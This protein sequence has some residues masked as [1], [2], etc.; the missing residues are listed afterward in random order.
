MAATFGIEWIVQASAAGIVRS[1]LEGT[2][3]ALLAALAVRLSG[4]HSSKTR[5]GVWFSALMTIAV[6]PFLTSVDLS[7]G[8]EL[9]SRNNIHCALTV[10]LSWALYLFGAWLLITVFGLLRIASGLLQMRALRKTC[11]EID[12]SELDPLM[13]ELLG[14]TLNSAA[15]SLCVSDR[16]RVPSAIGFFA[17]AIVIPRWLLRE[18]TPEELKQILLHEFEHLR[19]RDHWTN[20]AQKIV[21]ALFFFH[22]AVWWIEKQLSLQR[23]MACDEAVVAKTAKPRA[24]AECLARMA[25]KTAMERTLALAQAAFGHLRQTSLRLAKILS[26]PPQDRPSLWKPAVPLIAGLAIV[27]AS[28][29]AKEPQLIAFQDTSSKAISTAIERVDN[30]R[31]RIVP[32][33]FTASQASRNDLHPHPHQVRSARSKVVSGNAKSQ[34]NDF[35]EAIF[36][37]DNS[38]VQP[39]LV[40]TTGFVTNAEM[41]MEFVFVVVRRRVS[42]ASSQ[43]NSEIDVWRL[44]VL[45]SATP[46]ANTHPNET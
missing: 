13:R 32:A 20:L 42:A 27:G 19:R 6:L 11:S 35:Y 45:P 15:V 33:K 17:P 9:S 30:T 23:E 29:S 37:L 18:V 39:G 5:F 26:N 1:L 21:K 36:V 14:K 12:S 8:A 24:Y 46:S 16:V 2:A 25:E 31:P 43:S 22:P 4:P 10:P 40:H 38:T 41:R 3:I 44:T 28:I 7:H 34:P